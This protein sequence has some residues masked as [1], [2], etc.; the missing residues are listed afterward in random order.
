MPEDRREPKEESA[1]VTP[2]GEIPETDLVARSVIN[3]LTDAFRT[4]PEQTTQEGMPELEQ[5]GDMPQT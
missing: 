2:E 5:Q 4:G 1:E 3:P